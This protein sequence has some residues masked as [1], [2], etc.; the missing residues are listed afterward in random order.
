MINDKLTLEY[1]MSRLKKLFNKFENIETAILFGSIANNKI[2]YHDV[3]I[4]LKLKKEDLLEIGHIVSPIAKTLDIN[5]ERIDIVM[6]DQINPLLLAKILKEEIVIKA[7]FQTIEKLFQKAKQIP[8]TLI[9]FKQWAKIDPKLDKTI[10][11][12]RTEEIR[13]NAMFI[14]NEILSKKIKELSYKD[15]LALERV[16]HRIIE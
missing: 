11:I 4:A 12:S 15:I 16:I 8:D 3:D 10:I 6:L 5:E 1:L 9:E 7:S 13:K 14:K 2:S